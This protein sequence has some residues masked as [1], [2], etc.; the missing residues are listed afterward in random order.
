MNAKNLIPKGERAKYFVR[1]DKWNF[2]FEE[3][4]YHLEILYGMQDRKVTIQK[5]DFIYIDEQWTFSFPTD[6]MVG[7]VRARLVMEIFD[8]DCPD[9]V[10]EEVDEQYIGFVVSNPCPQF[11][12]CACEEVGHEIVYELAPVE[13]DNNG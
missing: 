3:N 8:P 5:A 6:E 7:P 4:S 2:G 11:Q 10:R 1:S 9:G 13:D 12:N